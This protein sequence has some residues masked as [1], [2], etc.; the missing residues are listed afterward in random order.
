MK[1]ANSRRVAQ[2]Y[3]KKA[4]LS[5][6]KRELMQYR[7]KGIPAGIMYNTTTMDYEVVEEEYWGDYMMGVRHGEFDIIENIKVGRRVGSLLKEGLSAKHEKALETANI[8]FKGKKAPK[9]KDLPAK[10]KKELE[11]ASKEGVDAWL[12]ATYIMTE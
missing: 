9:Y 12:E 3:I 8:S 4:N 1:I 6:A 2:L 5:K 10:L 11:G 7:R